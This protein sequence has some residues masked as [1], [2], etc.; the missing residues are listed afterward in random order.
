MALKKAKILVVEDE[1]LVGRELKATLEKLDYEVCAVIRSGEKALEQIS[2][3]QPDMVL[4]DITL[5]GDMDGIEVAREFDFDREVP[6]IFL[7]AHA[8][9]ATLERAKKAGSYGYLTKP[10]NETSLRNTLGV[11]L[12]KQK[13]E[14]KLLAKERELQQ[15]EKLASLGQLAAGVMHEINNP[16]SFIKGNLDFVFKAWERLEEYFDENPPDDDVIKNVLAELPDSFE[17]M[18]NGTERIEK[19]VNKVKQFARRGKHP[20]QHKDFG[21][22]EV[23]NEVLSRFPDIVDTE[24]ELQE[25][26][27]FEPEVGDGEKFVTH[28]SPEEL[29]QVLN[30]L[31]ENALH[32]VEDEKEPEIILEVCKSDGEQICLS[33]RDNG[34]GIPANKQEKIFDPFFTADKNEEGTGLGLSITKNILN[35]MGGSIEVE[36]TPGE[37]TEFRVFLPKA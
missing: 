27:A 7:T 6:V 25:I 37:G 35:R 4:M 8:D 28:G 18:Y 9:E 12:Y 31:L 16:N 11:A 24:L 23:V 3:H 17:A 15:A 29:E 14:Q 5:A 20:A 1:M 13:M 21:V 19:I 22:V 33:C 34:R 32:A 36:S 2:D 26:I 10:V 30:N